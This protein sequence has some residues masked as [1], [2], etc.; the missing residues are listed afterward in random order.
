MVVACRY[1]ILA[2]DVPL[3]TYILGESLL[4]DWC[5]V[6]IAIS[7]MAIQDLQCACHYCRIIRCHMC[8]RS[9]P[10]TLYIQ[11]HAKD[12]IG[13]IGPISLEVVEHLLQR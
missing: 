4:V 6:V 11:G 2:Y 10:C 5:H 9:L 1:Q 7:R 12:N 3:K 8:D 13:F